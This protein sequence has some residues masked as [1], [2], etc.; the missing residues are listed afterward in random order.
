MF[1]IVSDL[2]TSCSR[3][4]FIKVQNLMMRSII[5]KLLRRS[6]NPNTVYKDKCTE[7]IL[8]IYHSFY[9]LFLISMVQDLVQL[10]MV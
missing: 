10:M 2:K 4:G 1:A 5:G 7:M 8:L 9:P 6:M 3:E